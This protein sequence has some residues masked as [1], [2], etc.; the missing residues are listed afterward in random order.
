M[1]SRH[2]SQIPDSVAQSRWIRGH[3]GEDNAG[4]GATDS[5]WD[6]GQPGDGGDS[7]AWLCYSGGDE[8]GGWIFWLTS[9]EINGLDRIDGPMW[10][11][12]AANERPDR[13]CVAVS[14][15]IE[16]PVNLRP[17]STTEEVRQMLGKP[18]LSRVDALFHVHE[19]PATFHRKRFTVSITLSFFLHGGQVWAIA[20]SHITSD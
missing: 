16:L 14:G 8:T 17:G 19:H 13:R 2:G 3:V 9:G 20:G 12:L 7:E 18:S 1:A 11:R 6:D 10:R 4:Y 5:G 15:A